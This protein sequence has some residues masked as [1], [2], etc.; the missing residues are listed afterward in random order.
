ML[1]VQFLGQL[2]LGQSRLLAQRGQRCL[3]AF[4]LTRVNGF[5]H[6]RILQAAFACFQNASRAP[7]LWTDMN[8]VHLRRPS[9]VLDLSLLLAVAFPLLL[10]LHV[11]AQPSTP[12]LAEIKVAA[13][14]GNPTAQ[15]KLAQAYAMRL[16]SA[17][18]EA[19]YRKAAEQSYVHAQAK[20]GTMLLMR[21][22]MSSGHSVSD[23]ATAGAEAVKWLLLAANQGNRAAQADL[24]SVYLDG[25]LMP[26]DLAE[27]Y[28]WGELATRGSPIDSATVTGRSRRDAAVLKMTP[29]QI[30][31]ARKRV[32]SF[33]PHQLKKSELPAAPAPVWLQ[34]IKL[35][36]IGGGPG[37][38]FALI[39][40]Q[41]FQKSDVS[42]IR[43]G[44]NTVT[45]RC[46][47]IR[48]ASVIVSI[49][50]ID[51]TRELNLP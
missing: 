51:G 41:T 18:A 35:K 26:L 50:G 7:L 4:T 29:D 47:E 38:R 14:A 22:R 13:E 2:P 43:V 31:E 9:F 20:L 3:Q 40:N 6:L 15:D 27:A 19:W 36:G 1:P 49:D 10:L 46:V 48:D 17:Q 12:S 34:Q 24:A 16:D 44:T 32:A 33:V 8:A 25:K 5:I 37:N 28:K 39:N 30:E 11:N 42:P 23:R 45:I 21:N